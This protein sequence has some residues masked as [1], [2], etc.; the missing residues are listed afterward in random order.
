M[1]QA[2]FWL[3]DVEGKVLLARSGKQSFVC[4]MRQIKFC[5]QHAAGKVL[6]ARCGRQSFGC[7]MWQS[8]IRGLFA[9][10]NVLQSWL[11]V[12]IPVFCAHLLKSKKYALFRF[13]LST[14]V[15]VREIFLFQI[16]SIRFKQGETSYSRFVFA[17][18]ISRALPKSPVSCSLFFLLT[19]IHT[20]HLLLFLFL[21]DKQYCR[22]G[23]NNKEL[24]PYFC[25]FLC[26]WGLIRCTWS[27]TDTSFRPESSSKKSKDL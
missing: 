2:K 8:M 3:S 7:H 18:Y 15:E 10:R 24:V 12:F 21:P 9:F 5:L 22:I 11:Y 20:L 6:F 27:H 23:T 14:F 19:P 25:R 26:C 1:W 17:S 4:H 13:V 16:T